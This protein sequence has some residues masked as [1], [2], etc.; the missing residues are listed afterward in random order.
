MLDNI[1]SIKT[2]EGLF[3]VTYNMKPKCDDVKGGWMQVINLDMNRGDNCP[4]TWEEITTPRRLCL[5]D[6][7][8]C[9]VYVCTFS[10]K[11]S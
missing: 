10:C 5:G 7:A 4:D 9:W 3:E 1:Y 6:V 8:G 2:G 11:R